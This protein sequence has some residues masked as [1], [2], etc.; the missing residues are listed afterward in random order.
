MKK[1]RGKTIHKKMVR[2]WIKIAVVQTLLLLMF[3][4]TLINAAGPKEFQTSEVTVQSVC[5][6]YVSR[7]STNLLISDGVTTYRV[8]SRH[9]SAEAGVSTIEKSL[10]VGEKI[11]LTYYQSYHWFQPEY[12]VV[13]AHTETDVFRTVDEY[14]RSM[15]TGLIITWIV[16]VVFEC[17]LISICV[18]RMTLFKWW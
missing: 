5:T 6:V 16:F 11:K 14:Y 9:S 2:F 17:C 1:I 12:R 18:L 13:G 8:P 4:P 3:L 10:S 7:H 15:K